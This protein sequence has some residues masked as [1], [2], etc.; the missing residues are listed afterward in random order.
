MCVCLCW[1]A[2]SVDGHFQCELRWDRHHFNWY[3]Y[4]CNEKE[5]LSLAYFLLSSN[6]SF[7]LFAIYKWNL[8]IHL[9][10]AIRMKAWPS[11]IPDSGTVCVV[12]IAVAAVA[13]AAASIV[14]W[15]TDENK[16]YP[17]TLLVVNGVSDEMGAIFILL[18]LSHGVCSHNSFYSCNFRR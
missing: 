14:Y 15:P 4:I 5:N 12:V 9:L 17:F 7:S 6:C 18:H 2:I 3:I 10:S 16:W 11:V 1:S 13:V 8:L